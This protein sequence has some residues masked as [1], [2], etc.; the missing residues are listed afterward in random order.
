MNNII[1]RHPKELLVNY[2]FNNDTYVV[3]HNFKFE[4]NIEITL[5]HPLIIIGNVEA[6]EI[7]FVSK[8]YI[9]GDLTVSGAIAA[10]NPLVVEGKIKAGNINTSALIQARSIESE[11]NIIAKNIICRGT[12]NCERNI[13]SE[14]ITYSSDVNAGKC[15]DIEYNAMIDR[16]MVAGENIKVGKTLTVGGN[17]D[18]KNG[19]ITVECVSAG[20]IGIFIGA[21]ICQDFIGNIRCGKLQI[22]RKIEMSM[23]EIKAK[24]GIDPNDCLIVK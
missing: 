2:S 8:C 20:T 4:K 6:H 10:C 19:R 13:K 1:V 7:R 3:A 15:I 18:A 17:I 16:N 22:S 21:I 14:Y 5:D 23:S 12:I 11:K 24:L 9:Y